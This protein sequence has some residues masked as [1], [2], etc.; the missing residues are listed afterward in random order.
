M[1]ALS[2][3]KIKPGLYLPSWAGPIPPRNSRP[4]PLEELIEFERE[5]LYAPKR[6]RPRQVVESVEKPP[7]PLAVG[8]PQKFEMCPRWGAKFFD[9][10]PSRFQ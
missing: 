9:K 4:P 8:K 2:L 5:W 6:L 7:A 3:G 1:R 10:A